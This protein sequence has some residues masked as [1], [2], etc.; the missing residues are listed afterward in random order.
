[1][2]AS[3]G[4]GVM[5]DDGVDPRALLRRADTAMYREKR[6][7]SGAVALAQQPVKANHVA[8]LTRKLE[9]AAAT[10]D[11]EL[12]FQPVV[13]LILERTVG[14]EALL[15]WPVR[16]A[17]ARVL[18]PGSFIPLAEEL[19]LMREIGDWVM[20]ELTRRC[21]LWREE[22]VF[23]ELRFLSFN[24]SPRELWHPGFADRVAAMADAV[25]RPQLLIAE[26][27]ESALAMDPARAVSVLERVREHGVRVAIDDF[28]SGH[29][30]LARL[31]ELPIDLVKIDRGFL[32]GIEGDGP[33][34]S[35]VRSVLRLCQGLGVVALAEGVERRGQAEFLVREGCVLAQGFYFGEP[36]PPEALTAG[37]RR[38]EVLADAVRGGRDR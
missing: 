34:R 5:P 30:S 20:D 36:A 29:S 4:I 38:A 23:D 6:E 21:E 18:G 2:G 24:V 8:G 16:G 35:I 33:A 25:R 32:D 14:A 15:R 28:G 9:R 27:T 26:I 13:E 19:G 17:D 12:A 1:M 22:G 37:L 3:I 11:W 10:G 31:R 7:R